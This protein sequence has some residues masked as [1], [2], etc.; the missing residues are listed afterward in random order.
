[1]ENI[2]RNIILSA[3]LNKDLEEASQILGENKSTIIRNAL[4][5]YFDFL[6]LTIAKERAAKYESGIHKGLTA[7][8][9]KKE[10][11]I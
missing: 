4:V 11:D 9:V 3:N 5:Y 8:E 1:M 10:L 2:R 6:D 7:E